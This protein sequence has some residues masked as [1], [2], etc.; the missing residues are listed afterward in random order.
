MT[1]VKFVLL[2]L[3]AWDI[4]LGELSQKKKKKSKRV[5]KTKG[6]RDWIPSKCDRTQHNLRHQADS[7][8]ETCCVSVTQSSYSPSPKDRHCVMSDA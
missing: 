1:W 6:K 7:E 3:R 5:T 8:M 2:V 4:F